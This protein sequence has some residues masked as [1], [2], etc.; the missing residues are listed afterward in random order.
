MSF[1]QKQ[2]ILVESIQK[3]PHYADAYNDLA[4]LYAANNINLNFA[5]NLI[6]TALK[7]KPQGVDY[8]DTKAEILFKQ[9]RWDEAIAIEERLA[10]KDPYYSY[11]QEQIKKFKKESEK[12]SKSGKKTNPIHSPDSEDVP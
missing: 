12:K 4:S 9:K 10:E 2:T 11:H 5:L 7:T 6:E 1:A 3:Y 8:L